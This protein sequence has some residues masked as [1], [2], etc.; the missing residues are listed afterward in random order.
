MKRMS[1]IEILE[2][3]MQQDNIEYLVKRFKEWDPLENFRSMTIDLEDDSKEMKELL[4]YVKEK[5]M[6]HQ[7]ISGKL[8]FTDD[9]YDQLPY[10]RIKPVRPVHLGH[11]C[12][13]YGTQFTYEQCEKC[14]SG[15]VQQTPACFPVNRA[16]KY[17]FFELATVIIISARGKELLETNG[18]TGCSFREVIDSKTGQVDSRFY[19]IVIETYLPPVSSKTFEV[20]KRCFSCGS[21]SLAYAGT[22]QY[23]WSDFAEK[24]DFYYTSES[25]FLGGVYF[26]FRTFPFIVSKK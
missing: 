19:Q 10:Y 15:A 22:I 24:K 12:V 7:V 13:D 16:L 20:S 5:N 2:R 25:T 14:K 9:E 4:D 18:V 11:T 8:V 26:T 17:D 3:T 1:T 6:L 23:K 21:K